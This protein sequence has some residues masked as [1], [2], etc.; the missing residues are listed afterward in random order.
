MFFSMQTPPVLDL[1]RPGSKPFLNGQSKSVSFTDEME[2]MELENEYVAVEPNI[3]EAKKIKKTFA[4]ENNSAELSNKKQ[5][6]GRPVVEAS[7]YK[8][9]SL[10]FMQTAVDY[11]FEPVLPG[12]PGLKTGTAPVIRLYGVTAEGNSVLCKVH[13][14]LPYFFVQAPQH[15]DYA[16]CDYFRAYFNSALLE[17]STKHKEPVL[18]VEVCYKKS[19]FG[20]TEELSPFLRVTM[21]V[22]KLVATL[23]RIIE[24]GIHLGPKYGTLKLQP[25][26][27]NIEFVIRFMVDANIVGCNWIELPKGQFCVVNST[28]KQPDHVQ[29]LVNVAYDKIISYPAEGSWLK[30][31]PLRILSFDIECAG[32]EGHFPEPKLD[33]VIQ[34]AN[35]VMNLGAKKPF[36]RNVFTLGTCAHIVGSEIIQFEKEKE[37]LRKW[38]DFVLASDP[39]IITGYNITNFDLPFLVERAKVLGV[40]DFPYFGRTHSECIVKETTFSSR[41][42]GKRENKATGVDGRVTF[43]VFQFLQREYKLSSYTLN[44]VSA[45]FLNEQK[46]DVHH[47]IITTL[48]NGTDE[49]RRRLA[50]YCLKDAY[51]PLRLLDQ[52]MGLYNYIEMSRVTGV[53]LDSLLS[54]G[55][56]IKVVSQLMRKSLTGDF[57]IPTCNVHGSDEQFEGA[58]VIEPLTGYYNCPITTL[59]FTSLYP[60]V[61]MAH[62]LCYTTLLKNGKHKELKDD[63]YIRTPSGN[64]F[65]KGKKFKGL[66]P[67]ILE[68]LLAARKRAKHDLKNETDS[69]KRAVLDG[70][71][72]ALKIS[73][74]SVYGFTGATVGKLPCLEISSS[75]TAFGRQMIDK[76]KELVEGKYTIQNGYPHDAK[77]IY[78][79]T[80]SVMVKFGCDDLATAM[81]RGHEAASYVSSFFAHPIKLE[82][83]KVYFP[84]LLISK[85]RY[86]GLYWTKEDSYDKMDCKGI[87]T[88]RRDNCLLVKNVINVCLHKILIDRNL[89][90]AQQY[91]RETI[92]DLLQNKIDISQLVITKALSKQESE[93][94]GKQAHV[95]LAERM[96]QRDSSTAPTLGDRVPYVIIKAK[97]GAA[98]YEKSE[99]PI[100]VLENN[101]PIDTNYYLQNQLSKP[102]TRLF[103]PII[104]KTKLQSL[105]GDFTYF[106]L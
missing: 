27:A 99:D 90:G 51:L 17:S 63:E 59:D 92:A 25:Y 40:N 87:E 105:L 31:S 93:Y 32:R 5:I 53:P 26:E 94:S 75:V 21:A 20:Y 48:Q 13:G 44:A 79:D 71:Q 2:N 100:Y 3:I 61:M 28:A 69:F 78:G 46:E 84:Y 101:I 42:Y 18:K 52:L 47:S 66:L 104:G 98:A 15:F 6:W 10:L 41:A 36:I 35:M 91:C 58:T 55:Q 37:L 103:E 7:Y 14:F 83:E 9:H 4:E 1:K 8:D 11:T 70:R 89:E 43:D 16:D 97:K 73:A 96:R 12:M 33:P 56:Q 80:D 54:R 102:L 72:L 68:D 62:N 22:P 85:K 57:I 76:T 24:S 19:I 86:A 88:V 106:F 45:H 23:R 49:T 34:I 81:A 30:L 29:I 60:S 50:I 65:I 67:G 82:F 64:Y 74:N 77:V 38:K 39:D 95:A